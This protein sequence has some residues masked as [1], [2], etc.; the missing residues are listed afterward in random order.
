MFSV[1]ANVAAARAGS[2]G[3]ANSSAAPQQLTISTPA[4]QLFVSHSTPAAAAAAGP[5]TA[6]GAPCSFNPLPAAA[7]AGAVG[8]LQTT[9]INLAFD[10]YATAVEADSAGRGSVTRLELRHQGG[11]G[12]GWV[13]LPVANLTDLV[14]F[15]QP[16]PGTLAGGGGGLQAACV[17]WDAAL[18]GYSSAGCVALPSPLPP[19]VAA[20]WV[21]GFNA[22]AGVAALG[23]AWN[24]T[25]ESWS[26]PLLSGCTEATLDCSDPSQA[27]VRVFL[28][29]QAPLQPRGA[30]SCGGA[31][32]RTLRVFHGA[33]C[34]LWDPFN[35]ADCFWNATAQASATMRSDGGGGGS[36]Q[37]PGFT[38]RGRASNHAPPETALRRRFTATAALRRRRQ[39]AAAPT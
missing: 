16:A 18:G 37:R 19:G 36:G 38:H 5:I 30:I 6:P 17:F 32:A 26:G 35:D 20:Q 25:S 23:R 12:G 33:A 8:F 7:T 11:T 27:G 15:T 21:S 9:F 22:S 10:P 3:A 24:F 4:F 2:L 13:P 31:A 1:V 14:K 39:T 28:N 34:A 29:P